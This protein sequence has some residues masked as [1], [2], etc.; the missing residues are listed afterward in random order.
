MSKRN[1]N[2]QPVHDQLDPNSAGENFMADNSGSG[3]TDLPPDKNSG[4]DKKDAKPE[5]PTV[6][7][8]AKNLKVDA[9]VF[10]AVMQSNKWGSG[11][12]VPETVFAKAVKDFLNAPMGGK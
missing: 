10:A 12:K 3:G 4:F 6:E 11:K 5:F 9:P 8:H 7:E 1:E 2:D